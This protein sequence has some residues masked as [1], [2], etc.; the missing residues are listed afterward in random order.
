MLRD[1]KIEFERTIGNTMDFRLSPSLNCYVFGLPRDRG[2]EQQA[3][4]EAF[5]YTTN[6][7]TAPLPWIIAIA[8]GTPYGTIC[9]QIV[10]S[11]VCGVKVRV[12]SSL[13]VI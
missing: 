10:R 13:I 8:C 3:Q 6:T 9:L 7:M 5:T 1:I 2:T 11:Q 4:S 12:S